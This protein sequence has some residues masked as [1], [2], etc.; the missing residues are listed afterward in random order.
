MRF[1]IPILALAAIFAAW[2]C[3]RHFASAPSLRELDQQA[4]AQLNKVDYVPEIVPFE[5]HD[6][7]RAWYE[8]KRR[9]ARI[10]SEDATFQAGCAAAT[11]WCGIE[12]DCDDTLAMAGICKP[13]DQIYS[14]ILPARDIM[15]QSDLL[16]LQYFDTQ[17]LAHPIVEATVPGT[18]K[19]FHAR[20]AAHDRLQWRRDDQRAADMRRLEVKLS[21][22]A[23]IA[24]APRSVGFADEATWD[25]GF[26]FGQSWLELGSA[27]WAAGIVRFDQISP[28][29]KIKLFPY[30]DSRLADAAP[31][32][33]SAT[34]RDYFR[35]EVL[36]VVENTY[37][38]V[39]Q[40]LK[41]RNTMPHTADA[42]T[43]RML[44]ELLQKLTALNHLAKDGWRG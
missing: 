5:N 41:Y 38:G 6:K 29:T 8:E 30:V 7:K 32:I 26:R 20:E 34:E 18:L 24:N 44:N 14:S 33:L 2:L 21:E 3:Y 42:D 19:A 35:T 4:R 40:Y 9:A 28:E 22:L 13:G 37:E 11:E 43:E 25:A 12:I 15:A 16:T 23:T 36:I 17:V 39:R 27:S 10:T 31:I 1:A